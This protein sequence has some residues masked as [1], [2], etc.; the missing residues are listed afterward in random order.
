MRKK[1]DIKPFWEIMLALASSTQITVFFSPPSVQD[2]LSRYGYLPP[3]DPRTGKLQTKEGIEKAIRVMQRF[4]GVPETG[5]LGNNHSTH[6]NSSCVKVTWNLKQVSSSDFVIFQTVKPSNSCPHHDAPCLTL[7][8]ERTC[9][10]G[11][12]GGKDMPCQALS[13]IRRT[14]HGG[15]LPVMFLWFYES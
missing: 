10:R 5:T 7:L 14:S 6:D 13:G 1:A 2:W 12:G 9:W 8:V 4:G 3:P 15:V 11:G